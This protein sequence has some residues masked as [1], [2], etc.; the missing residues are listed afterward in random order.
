MNDQIS[1]QKLKT[2]ES[3][4]LITALTIGDLNDL[5]DATDAAIQSGGGF[6]WV[7]LPSRDILERYWQGVVTMPQ[8]LLFVGRLD[9]V[10]CATAQLVLPPKNNEAQ[11]HAVKLTTNFTV[12]WARGQGISE[13]LLKKVFS[14]AREKGFKVINL[15]V[16]ETQ[17]AAIKFYEKHGFLC[18][19]THPYYAEID[20]K[21]VPGRHYYKILED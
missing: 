15:G 3:V 16:R 12:P 18:V 20:G 8:R 14:T 13:K 1:L 19:G 2:V 10:I 21:P 5:C 17:E 11:A 6:G 7:K 4:E 9:G